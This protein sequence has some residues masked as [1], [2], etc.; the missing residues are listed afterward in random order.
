M[1][2]GDLANQVD[3]CGGV[4]PRSVGAV[5]K[6]R[7]TGDRSTRTAAKL[8]PAASIRRY[9]GIASAEHSACRDVQLQLIKELLGRFNIFTRWRY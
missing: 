1:I 3:S 9:W 8:V 4:P 7:E 5:A 6:I 2:A